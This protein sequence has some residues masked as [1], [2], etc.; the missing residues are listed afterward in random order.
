MLTQRITLGC[1]VS[2]ASYRN[3]VLLVKMATTLD[4][5]SHG[6]L[7][8][9][10]G[11]GWHEREHRAMGYEL[12]APGPRIARLADAAAI[13]RGLLE[14]GAVTY[15]GKYFSADG[16]RNDP[17][18]HDGRRVPLLIGGSGERRTLMVVARYADIWN[19][20]GDPATIEH[21]LGG[22]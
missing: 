14:D 20:A 16:A 6:R 8:V 2:G 3:P 12:L 9:G 11:A 10:L 17:P 21:K 22:L 15:Q 4:R 5:A 13:V 1:L 7:I 18:A 19:G